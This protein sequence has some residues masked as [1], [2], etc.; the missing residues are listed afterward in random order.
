MLNKNIG[1]IITAGLSGSPKHRTSA[2]TIIISSK[3]IILLFKGIKG[4]IIAIR[5][6]VKRGSI[7]TVGSH[8]MSTNSL[9]IGRLMLSQKICDISTTIWILT[10]ECLKCLQLN[11]FFDEGCQLFKNVNSIKMTS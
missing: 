3:E 2:S 10:V 5:Q 8:N 1:L 4:V 11:N 7:L 9:A 6:L